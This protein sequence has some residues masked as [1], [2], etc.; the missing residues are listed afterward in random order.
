MAY[1]KRNGIDKAL[2]QV[3]RVLENLEKKQVKR[4]TLEN[5][6]VQCHSAENST[7]EIGKNL[8]RPRGVL[9]PKSANKTRQIKQDTMRNHSE[10]IL[11]DNTHKEI[12]SSTP[13]ESKN[14]HN[15]TSISYIS[16]IA[17]KNKKK[18]K[19]KSIRRIDR[20][21]STDI[22]R[23][24]LQKV[25]N[26]PSKNISTKINTETK[27]NNMRYIDKENHKKKSRKRTVH[28]ESSK[29]RISTH[30]EPT[31]SSINRML[32]TEKIQKHQDNI[33]PYVPVGKQ[34]GSHNCGVQIQQEIGKLLLDPKAALSWN[35]KQDLIKQNSDKNIN[36]GS[37]SNFYCKKREG[38][39]CPQLCEEEIY[40][41]LKN[42]NKEISEFIVKSV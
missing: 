40:R 11:E 16:N 25:E 6:S 15:F 7:K 32:L 12:L 41:A 30:A 42:V 22:S 17:Q 27:T 9:L 3:D 4:K 14:S 19:R 2:D 29:S 38:K 10:R 23:C 18:L 39:D 31:Q 1:S 33:L 8:R 24:Y 20:N 5:K 13:N 35:E 28:S 37:I 34:S 26:H 36:A 21:S